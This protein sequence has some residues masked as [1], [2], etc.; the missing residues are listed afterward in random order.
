M[1]TN[2]CA[3]AQGGQQMTRDIIIPQWGNDK[4]AGVLGVVLI[5]EVVWAQRSAGTI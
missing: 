5:A 1:I 4:E 2:R 3:A